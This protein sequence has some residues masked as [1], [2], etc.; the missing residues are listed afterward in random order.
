M[1]CAGECVWEFVECKDGEEV[2]R[3]ARCD[4]EYRQYTD[5]CSGG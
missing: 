3:C 1:P 5:L 2:Y 4:D